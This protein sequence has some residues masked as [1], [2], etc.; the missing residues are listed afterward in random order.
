MSASDPTKLRQR[1]EELQLKLERFDKE[2]QS[3]FDSL[4]TAWSQLDQVWDG[5]AYQEF[6]GHWNGVRSMIQQYLGKSNSYEQFLQERIRILEKYERSG[7][8]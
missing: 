7:G 6:V 8:I 5:M 3:G 2:L 1:L 4:D